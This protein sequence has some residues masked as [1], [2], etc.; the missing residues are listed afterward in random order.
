MLFTPTKSPFALPTRTPPQSWLGYCLSGKPSLSLLPPGL[1]EMAPFGY[2][3]RYL[4]GHSSPVWQWQQVLMSKPQAQ[5]QPQRRVQVSSTDSPP[6]SGPEGPGL[7]SVR[8]AA[9]ISLLVPSNYPRFPVCITSF[10]RCSAGK[11]FLSFPS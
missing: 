1:Q 9:M 7:F 11:L 2:W 3:L 4:G 5:Q 6:S 10:P 8:S